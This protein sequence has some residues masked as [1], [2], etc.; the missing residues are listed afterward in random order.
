MT[1]GKWCLT[2][3]LAPILAGLL[4]TNAVMALGL[5]GITVN[6]VLNEPLDAEIV[7]S[8]VGDADQSLL[9]VE[10]ASSEAFS[11]A[12]VVRDY[13]LTQLNFSVGNNADGEAVINV[14]SDAAVRKSYLNFLV[15]LEWPAGRLI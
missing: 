13:Y 6:S 14:S 2:L 11:E 3:A 1:I 12:G 10:L 8:N 4:F 5:G 9:R 7:L 15:Q